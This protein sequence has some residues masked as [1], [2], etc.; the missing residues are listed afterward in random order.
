M[1]SIIV[2][3]GENHAFLGAILENHNGHYSPRVWPT[4]KT[5]SLPKPKSGV[6]STLM[7]SDFVLNFNF[8]FNLGDKVNF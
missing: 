4:T 8:N 1:L 2:E 5:K 7:R 3:D 6:F